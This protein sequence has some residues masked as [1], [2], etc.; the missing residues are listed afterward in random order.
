MTST[1][2]QIISTVDV[3]SINVSD[4]TF[5]KECTISKI[6]HKMK[7]LFWNTAIKKKNDMYVKKKTQTQTI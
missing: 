1:L 4:E 5:T 7:T 3:K 2:L 6:H